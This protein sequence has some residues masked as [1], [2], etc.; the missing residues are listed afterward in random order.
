[1]P[2]YA[3]RFSIFNFVYAYGILA[4]RFVK[5]YYG[6]DHNAC[7]RQDLERYGEK[8]VMDEKISRGALETIRRMENAHANSMEGYTFFVAGVLLDLHA[9]VPN[10]KL[11][12]LIAV[13]SVSRIGFGLAYI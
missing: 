2:S 6:F 1:I 8:I 10:E 11:N 7:P 3:A 9:G 12:G 5:S 4:T 13:H